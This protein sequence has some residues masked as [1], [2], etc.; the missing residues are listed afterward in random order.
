MVV[1]MHGYCLGGGNI[2]GEEALRIGLVDHLVPQKDFFAHLDDVAKTY[3]V[4]CSNG[5]LNE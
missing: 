3:L 4:A 1:G 2:P 5:N